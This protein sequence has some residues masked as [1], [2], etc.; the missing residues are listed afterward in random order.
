[1]SARFR[2]V[3]LTRR[4]NSPIALTSQ[5]GWNAAM[6]GVSGQVP[7]G[8]TSHWGIAAKPGLIVLPATGEGVEVRPPALPRASV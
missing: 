7:R 4:L 2:P 1:M 8:H 6:D 3:L 5:D